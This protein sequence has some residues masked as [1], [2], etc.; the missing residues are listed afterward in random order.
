MIA[1]RANNVPIMRALIERGANQTAKTGDGRQALWIA[2]SMGN[3]EAVKLL[4]SYTKTNLNDIATD[5]LVTPLWVAAQNGHH[6]V[7][8][9]I[10][11]PMTHR[12]TFRKLRFDYRRNFKYL[13]YFLDCDFP[14]SKWCSR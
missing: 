6:E 13:Y 4:V 1:S 14:P 9:G 10:S 11:S 12:P 5:K 2:S 8:P 7:R 3:I